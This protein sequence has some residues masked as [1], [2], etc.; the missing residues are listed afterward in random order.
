MNS[1]L[2]ERSRNS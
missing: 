2:M 1:D